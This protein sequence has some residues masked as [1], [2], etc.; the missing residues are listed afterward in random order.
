MM[1]R[2]GIIAALDEEL[3][4]LVRVLK[5]QRTIEDSGFTIRILSYKDKE[6]YVSRS[7]AGEIKATI[8]ATLLVSKYGCECLINIGVAGKLSEDLKILDCVIADRVVHYQYDIS[9]IDPVGP[10]TYT[11]IGQ[12]EIMMDEDLRAKIA[13]R[14]PDTR[15]VISASGDKFIGKE[16]DKQYL[17][18]TFKADICEMEGAGVILTSKAFDIPCVLI[19][20]I[21]DDADAAVYENYLQKAADVNVVTLIRILGIL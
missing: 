9:E 17:K 12:P 15:F 21:S 10:G 14:Y 6:V 18:D 8:L 20:A 16:E 3:S 19:R 7:G 1:K 11:S 4:E 5:P 2:I 13:E